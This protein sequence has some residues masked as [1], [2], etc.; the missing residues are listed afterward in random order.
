MMSTNDTTTTRLSISGMRRYAACG[1]AYKLHQDGAPRRIT[2]AIWYGGIVH[3]IIQ[4]AYAGAAPSDAHEQVWAEECGSIL[5][6]LEQWSDLHRACQASGKPNTRAREAWLVSHPSYRTLAEHLQQYQ[7]DVLSIYAWPKTASVQEYFLRSRTLV[8]EH[9]DALLL[10]YAV[11]VEGNLIAPLPDVE[12]LAPVALAVDDAD[13]PQPYG[14]LQATIGATTVAGV[15]DVVAYEPDRRHWR[16]GNYKTAKTVLT[17]EA[18]REDAQMGAY[19]MMAHQAGII[20]AGASVA[21]GHI[22]VSDHV[23]AVW[24]DVTDRVGT[25]ARRLVQQVE[26]TRALIEAEIFMPVKGLLNGYA[27]RCTGC[28][29]AHVCD[30]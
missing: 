30:A 27:D 14:L 4:R 1:Y 19:L 3:R 6:A 16:I 29:F 11:M 21:I 2:A 9:G 22:Y 23:E 8:R 7:A 17:P 15:P 5:A 25:A 12:A 26:Q 18:L 10:P 28:M 13:E 20:R 24:V